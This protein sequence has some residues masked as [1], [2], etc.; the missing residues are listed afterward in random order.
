[1][2]IEREATAAGLGD[3]VHPPAA[4]VLIF[5]TGFQTQIWLPADLTGAPSIHRTGHTLDLTPVLTEAD[6]S[7]AAWFFEALGWSE[8]A[9]WDNRDGEVA[10]DLLIATLSHHGLPLQ[11]KGVRA[12]NP[13]LW[14]A[15]KDLEPAHAV[16][17]IGDKMRHCFLAAWD[18]S[19]PP[20]PDAPAFQHLFLAL[21]TLADWL[22]SN[23]LWF[24]FND[25][26]DADY[27]RCRPR[28]RPARRGQSRRAPD[29]HRTVR[30]LRGNAQRHPE[31][32]RS[33]D[34]ARRAAGR[35]RIG[36]RLRQTEAALWRFTRM[37]EAGLVDGLYFVLPTHAAA[38]H[39]PVPLIECGSSGP[40][41]VRNN[42]RV[43]HGWTG[44]ERGVSLTG[45]GAL[46]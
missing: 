45:L 5:D 17:G 3:G 21:C 6:A 1:M 36:N 37:Y 7:A 23:E 29:F 35:H 26:P 13:V 38:A 40:Q 20:L 18:T 27:N 12:P 30:H 15:F 10:S 8:F 19:A 2:Q 11:L 31:P 9:A 25:D 39:A 46:C 24:P 16:R 28:A 34:G 32:G 14:R 44:C 42:V 41:A 4:A 33:G 22:G 43:R